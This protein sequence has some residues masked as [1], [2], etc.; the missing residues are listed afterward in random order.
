MTDL[1]KRFE[2]ALELVAGPPGVWLGPPASDAALND[3]ESRLEGPLPPDLRALLSVANGLSVQFGQSLIL[4]VGGS[5]SPDLVEF[6]RHDTWKYAWPT[7]DLAEALVYEVTPEFHVGFY[8]TRAGAHSD[9]MLML[10]ETF[11]PRPADLVTMVEK[12]WT[13]MATGPLG[14]DGRA[15]YEAVG[16][17]APD[18]GVYL[19]KTFFF[20][21]EPDSSEARIF[22]LEQVFR[23]GGGLY[24]DGQQLP[25]NTTVV[26]PFC[27]DDDRGRERWRWVTDRDLPGLGGT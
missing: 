20:T 3:A 1:K 21:G 10:P 15:I 22:P 4:G 19:G 6:N 23:M 26:A 12:G 14:P 11:Q 7:V 18:Q 24:H 16:P 13:S 17:V 5:E 2:R 25:P 27:E 8:M 9:G